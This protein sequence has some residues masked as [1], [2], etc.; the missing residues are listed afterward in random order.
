VTVRMLATTH[1][2]RSGFDRAF[3]LDYLRCEVMELTLAPTS[4]PAQ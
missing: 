4:V 1:V 2:Y 3:V